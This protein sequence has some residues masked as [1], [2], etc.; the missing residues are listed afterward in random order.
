MATYRISS[1]FRALVENFSIP[2]AMLLPADL[3]PEYAEG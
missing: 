1:L 2:V 3:P